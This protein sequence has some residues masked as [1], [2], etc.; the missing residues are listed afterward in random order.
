MG[1]RGRGREEERQ[2]DYSRQTVR[3][4][5]RKKRGREGSRV[6]LGGDGEGLREGDRDGKRAEAGLSQQQACPGKRRW[7]TSHA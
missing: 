3:E 2:R 1:G 4:R 6:E 5:G 7:H